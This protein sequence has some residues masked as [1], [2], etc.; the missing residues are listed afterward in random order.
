MPFLCYWK[1]L[2]GSIRCRMSLLCMSWRPHTVYLIVFPKAFS[3]E[4]SDRSED[5]WKLGSW[6][7]TWIRLDCAPFF[8]LQAFCSLGHGNIEKEN[9]RLLWSGPIIFLKHHFPKCVLQSSSFLRGDKSCTKKRGVSLGN[10]I[11]VLPFQLEVLCEVLI[12]RI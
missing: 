10:S 8:R 7:R 11:H 1:G 5:S 12:K 4:I 3:L 6:R 2:N 9:I